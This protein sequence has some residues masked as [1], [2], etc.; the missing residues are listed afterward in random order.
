MP[1]MSVGMSK[2]VSS[3][4]LGVPPS[5]EVFEDLSLLDMFV[6][7]EA[8][9]FAMLTRKR[10]ELNEYFSAL[11]NIFTYCTNVSTS[12]FSRNNCLI[13]TYSSKN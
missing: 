9:K 8:E 7:F 10:N 2:L 6:K 5:L 1:F 4:E 13:A 11:I 3:G 12:F